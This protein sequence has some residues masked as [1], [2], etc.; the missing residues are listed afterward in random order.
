MAPL[1]AK[2]PGEMNNLPWASNNNN[3]EAHQVL[4]RSLAAAV[5]SAWVAVALV[6]GASQAEDELA[7]KYGNG[8]MLDTSLVDQVSPRNS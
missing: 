5:S 8:K 2:K 3:A 7:S 6:G 1:A 4:R